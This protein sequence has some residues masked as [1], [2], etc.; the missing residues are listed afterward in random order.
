MMT[1]IQWSHQYGARHARSSQVKNLHTDY[2]SMEWLGES[3]HYKTLYILHVPL[4][5]S[6]PN[7]SIE[8]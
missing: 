2:Q 7:L 4:W 8:E 3:P 1:Q 6:L 5:P